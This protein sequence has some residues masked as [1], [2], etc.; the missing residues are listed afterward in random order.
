MKR[1]IV[2]KVLAAILMAVFATTAIAADSRSDGDSAKPAWIDGGGAG[3]G[4]SGAGV[5][6]F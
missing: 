3:G 2:A 1:Y 6:N 5:G 4:A